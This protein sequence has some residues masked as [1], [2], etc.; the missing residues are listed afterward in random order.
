MEFEGKLAPGLG[1]RGRPSET[2]EALRG[3]PLTLE[4]PAT[5]AQLMARVELYAGKPV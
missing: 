2:I 3:S 1:E 5:W 4:L